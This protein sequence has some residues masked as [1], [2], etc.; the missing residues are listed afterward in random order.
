MKTLSQKYANKDTRDGIAVNKTY[1]VP[2]DQL[3]L[4]PG[5]TY[6]MPMSSMLLTLRS[7]GLKDRRFLHSQLLSPKKAR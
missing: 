6:V 5:Y 4:E 7:A 3:Y 2:F 1:L